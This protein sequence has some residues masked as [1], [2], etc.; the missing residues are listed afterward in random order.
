MKPVEDQLTY[1]P[2]SLTATGSTPPTAGYQGQP[3]VVAQCGF[4]D[5]QRTFTGWNTMEDGTGTTY[6]PG[7]EYV[8]T[9]GSDVLYAQ[10][11]G[12]PGPDPEPDVP[13]GNAW[14]VFSD[15][16][17][18]L[19][20]YS[21]S[22]DDSNYRNLCYVLHEFDEPVWDDSGHPVVE[23]VTGELMTEILGYRVKYTSQRGSW[24]VRLEDDYEDRETWLDKRDE[25]PEQ[26]QDWPRDMQEEMP[27]LS[28]V[29]KESYDQFK[30][31]LQNEGRAYLEENYP[32]V[33]N[34]DT[35]TLNM[36]GYL[37]GFDL[38]DKVDMEVSTLGLKETARIIEVDEVHESGNSEIHLVMGE[39]MVTSTRKAG[40][41]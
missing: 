39:E 5:S 15:K 12:G 41:N 14:A 13:D 27:D 3:V 19:Y 40:L 4:I 16:W 10:W 36:S 22:V 20:D 32:I 17:G 31:S 2:N 11:T 23:T 7:S 24:V 33:K 21:A 1:Y 6:Q 35:G 26:D 25:K 34:L 28:G 8:L 37:T 30:T 38:G 29:T 18:S 9:E